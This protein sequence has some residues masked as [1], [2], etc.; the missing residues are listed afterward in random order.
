VNKLKFLVLACVAAGSFL[1]ANAEAAANSVVRFRIS[2]GATRFGDIDV[3]LFDT[4]KPVTV[5]NFLYYV[6]TDAF[7]RSFLHRCVNDSIGIVQGGLYA[8]DNPYPSTLFEKLTRIPEGPPI[9]NEFNVGP[10]ISNTFGTLAMGLSSTNIGGNE[11]PLLDTATTS[12]FFNTVDNTD[13]LDPNYAVF[14]RVKAGAS[15]LKFFNTLS[16]D[17]GIINMNSLSFLFSACDYPYLAGEGQVAFTLPVAY[18]FFDCPYYSDLFNVQISMLS[19][20]D[21]APPKITIAPVGVKQTISNDMHTVSGTVT[22]NVGVEQVR[23]YLGT[24]APITAALN[25]N[26]HTWSATLTNIPPGTNTFYVEATDFAGNRLIKTASFF[27]SAT[28]KINLFINGTSC[29]DTEVGTNIVTICGGT[30]VGATNGQLL[31]IGRGQMITAVPA[32]GNLFAGWFEAGNLVSSSPTYPFII[33][34]DQMSRNITAAFNTNLFPYV[35]G[36]YTGVFCNTSQVEEP[37]SGFMSLTVGDLGTYSAKV[38]IDGKTYP[39]TGTFNSGNGQN[40]NF[41]TRPGSN[42]ILTVRMTL[43]LVPPSIGGSEHISGSISNDYTYSVLTNVMNEVIATNIVDGMENYVTNFVTV[44][45]NMFFRTNWF[46]ELQADRAVFGSAR[47]APMAG[48]YTLLIPADTNSSTGPFGDGYARVSINTKGSL[49][50]N[51]CLADGTKVTQK[52]P[53]SKNGD[54]PLYLN[55]YK[56]KGTLLSRIVLDTNQPDTD[57]SGLMNWFKRTQVAKYY[58]GGFTN[59]SMIV[60]SRFTPPIGTNRLLGLTAAVVGFTNGNLVVDFANDVTL[61]AAGKVTNLDTNRLSLNLNKSSGLM[62][63]SFTPPA[64]TRAL[65]LKGAVLQKQNRGAGYFLGTNS[66]GRVS[67]D[68]P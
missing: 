40:L 34:P 51:G 31:E 45:T 35:K 7:D 50:F 58:P 32:P 28:T 17:R 52:V 30:I 53:I 56:N 12:W 24:G 16:E 4:D 42:E 60:G 22:D 6:Q 62:T 55:L 2:Y 63:G 49:T 20:R 1:A 11:Y 59:E 67:I 13:Q 10:R 37:S 46:A 61:D 64:G 14:G 39:M 23:V 27:R 68:A 3:E 5:S 18:F 33:N 65:P 19:G 25:T 36:T 38:S 47:P 15:Y 66:S 54:W 8:V 48:N 29:V 9:T 43:D 26:N 57:L 44:L 21:V 41:L